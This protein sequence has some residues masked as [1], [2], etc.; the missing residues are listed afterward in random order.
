MIYKA[1]SNYRPDIDGL[2]AL[3]VLSVLLF[4]GFP[5]VLPGGFAGVDIFFVISGFLITGIIWQE[6]KEDKFS[7]LSFYARRVRRIFPA[8]IIV[9]LACTFLGWKVL[10]DDEFKQLGNHIMR[11]GVFLSNF[12]LWKESGYFDSRAELKP[13]LHLWSLAIEEQFYIIWPA[14]I[15]LLYRKSRQPVTWLMV[16]LLLSF[17]WN[18]Y[19]SFMNP[20]HDF[21]SPLTRFWE[22]MAGSAWA[23]FSKSSKFQ[24]NEEWKRTLGSTGLVLLLS[25]MVIVSWSHAY[26]GAWAVL[27]VLGAVCFI[28]AEGELPWL[29]HIFTH[30]ATLWVGE[31]S[32]ALY[33]WH[34]PILSFLRVVEGQTPTIF[35]RS[36]GLLLSVVLAALTSSLIEKKFRYGPVMRGK[37][38]FLLS[39][40]LLVF[41]AGYK[42]YRTHG[43]PDRSLMTDQHVAHQGD[44]GH[45][46]FHREYSRRFYACNNKKIK[47]DA[48]EWMGLKRCFQSQPEG[49]IDVLLLGDSHAEHLL[50]GLSESLP[51]QHVGFYG[52]NGLPLLSNRNYSVIF[53]EVLKDHSVRLVV[54]SA[55]WLPRIQEMLSRD[56]FISDLTETIQALSKAGKKVI[57][58]DDVYQFEFDPQRCKYER[59]FSGGST[60]S[61]PRDVAER[62]FSKYLPALEEVQKKTAVPFI[63]IGD[64]LCSDQACFML[65]GDRMAYRDNNHLNSIGSKQVA[66]Q[67]ISKMKTIY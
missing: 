60:C 10:F 38:I 62:E 49:P 13:L 51:D 61:V 53:E 28:A 4:H 21:Y 26:P 6:N 34:W 22:L 19:Q 47:E 59:P 32:Y 1:V 5:E 18:I 41:S 55:M 54:I 42:I 25:S 45:D 14:L 24:L 37:I 58:L 2:R 65:S 8:L 48:G 35:L 15:A 17:L 27:P 43:F 9:L 33:L 57:L 20:V 52:K 36:M 3:A 56:K 23:V 66:K 16:L 63:R 46:E 44:I 29:G 11:A 64:A 39:M 7:F 40:M 50:I 31:I 30:R 67:L 12:V